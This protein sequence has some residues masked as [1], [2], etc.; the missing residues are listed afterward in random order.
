MAL[1][2][3]FC[4]DSIIVC[5]QDHT[6]KYTLCGY[7][8]GYTGTLCCRRRSHLATILHCSKAAIAM[9]V[10]TTAKGTRRTFLVSHFNVWNGVG[11]RT[12]W[13]GSDSD[14]IRPP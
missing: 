10:E 12:R 14:K 9:Q 1:L 11:V 2:H 3:G 5:I 7:T 8:A 13:R 4:A 6:Q